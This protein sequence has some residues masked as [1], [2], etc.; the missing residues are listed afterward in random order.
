M[1]RA[2]T[3][4]INTIILVRLSLTAIILIFALYLYLLSITVSAAVQGKQDFKTI[5]SLGQE[6]HNLESQYFNLISMVDLDYAH[7]LGFVDQTHKADYVI[8]QTS[9][10]RR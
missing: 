4:K 1:T 8:R 9:F 5:Q 10:A 2:I 3:A 6:Y 7:Q